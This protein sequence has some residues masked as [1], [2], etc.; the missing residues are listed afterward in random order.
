MSMVSQYDLPFSCGMK[1]LQTHT[2]SSPASVSYFGG[3]VGFFFG[4]SF[5]FAPL[6][7]FTHQSY[8]WL[9]NTSVSTLSTLPRLPSGSSTQKVVSPSVCCQPSGVSFPFSKS[10]LGQRFTGPSF[11]CCA[12]A[13]TR[14][15]PTASATTAAHRQ[16]ITFPRWSVVHDPLI[17]P[18]PRP[19]VAARARNLCYKRIGTPDHGASHGLCAA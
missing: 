9:C 1:S 17:I 2:P 6:A 8:A 14:A 3:V 7:T 5:A 11:A 12:G 18:G 19:F 4:A 13:G 10:P 16:S 15:A